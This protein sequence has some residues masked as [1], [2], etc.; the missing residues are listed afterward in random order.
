MT[1]TLPLNRAFGFRCFG[2]VT[3]K[4][5]VRLSH[6]RSGANRLQLAVHGSTGLVVTLGRTSGSYAW[7]GALCFRWHG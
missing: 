5:V 6:L 1:P 7:A 3:E 4:L 2:L